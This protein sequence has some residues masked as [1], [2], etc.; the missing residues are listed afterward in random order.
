MQVFVLDYINIPKTFDLLDKSRLG[1]QMNFEFNI[2]YIARNLK[3]NK[4]YIG[5]TSKLL[6]DRIKQH[7]KS[8]KNPK[9]YFHYAIRKYGENCFEWKIISEIDTLKKAINVEEFFI[10][11]YNSTDHVFGYNITKCGK[12]GGDVLSNHPRIKEI[13][14]NKDKSIFK[15]KEFRLKISKIAKENGYGKWMLG[16]RLSKTH[17]NNISKGIQL[18]LC[19]ENKRQKIS[20]KGQKKK[21]FSSEHRM[22][23]SKLH[24]G[25]SKSEEHKRKISETLKGTK[26][27]KETIEKRMVKIR[28][29][30]ICKIC[31]I[32]LDNI[33]KFEEHNKLYHGG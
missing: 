21:D 11:Y 22:K 26:Q 12:F 24:K 4:V 10:K 14:D 9:S 28:G 8:S 30:K 19:D 15:T 17:R 25:K 32:W 7:L 1:K 6:E 5:R 18:A 16:K 33:E 2:V 20:H 3:N 31:N 29:R 27:S 23:L 13:C